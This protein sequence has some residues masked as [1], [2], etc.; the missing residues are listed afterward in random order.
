[1]QNPNEFPSFLTRQKALAL[2]SLRELVALRDLA[3]ADGDWVTVERVDALS[4]GA[5]ESVPQPTKSADSSSSI[6]RELPSRSARQA[7]AKHWGRT[8]AKNR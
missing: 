6:Q 4:R 7:E 5:G 8:R 2:S 3:L 1:M